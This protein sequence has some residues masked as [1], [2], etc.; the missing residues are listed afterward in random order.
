[1]TD[2]SGRAGSTSVQP[3]AF[4]CITLPF[5]LI[6]LVPLGWGARAQWANGELDRHGESARGRV[7]EVRYIASNP[8]VSQSRSSGGSPIVAFTTRSGEAR[9]MTGSVNRRPAPWRAGDEVEVVYDAANPARADLR[10]EI[11][12]WKLWF[13]IWCAVALL[14]TAVASLPIVLLIRQRRAQPRT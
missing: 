1:L 9:S 14:P 13:A 11:S 5:L 4:G 8:S 3:S 12:G 6:A 10:S 7:T 2:T